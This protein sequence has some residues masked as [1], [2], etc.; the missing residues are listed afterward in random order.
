MDLVYDNIVIGGGFFGLYLANFL[1]RRNKSVLLLEKENEFMTKASYNNQA[2]IH[3]G[4]HY[5]RSLLTAL[6]SS[7]SFPIFVDDFHQCIDDSFDKYYAIPKIQSK[8][9][10]KQFNEFTKNIDAPCE[11]APSKIKSLF[12]RDLIDEVFLTKEFAFDSKKLKDEIVSRLGQTSAE[13]K[14]AHQVTKIEVEEQ[15]QLFK[16]TTISND[17]EDT[18]LAHQ[19]FNCTYS[20]IN[21][22]MK[23]LKIEDIPIIN[24][25]AEICLIEPPE[26][27]RNI[28]ITVMCGPFFSTMPFPAENLHSF[29]HVSFTPHSEWREGLSSHDGTNSKNP[30]SGIKTHFGHMVRDTARYLPIISDSKY[31]KSLWEIKTVLPRNSENDGRPILFKFDYGHKGLHC[32]VGAKIDNVYDMIKI[33]ENDSERFKL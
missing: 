26:E 25:V 9:S 14:L 21:K 29:S 7:R 1:A 16:V 22:V 10:A 30:F 28:G 17:K 27:I 6:R 3:H 31:K 8:I 33:M 23:D 12:N 11:V 24:E 32:I 4:Y 20:S 5:P 19:V 13:T 15:T 18:F 2:R